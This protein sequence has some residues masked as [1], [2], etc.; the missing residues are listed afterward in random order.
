MV[1][2]VVEVC[3]CVC[4]CVLAETIMAGWTKV[5]GGAPRRQR[6]NISSNMV[7]KSRVE[8]GGLEQWT[9]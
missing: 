4:V 9:S 8:P 3:V 6:Y 1:V 5:W 2:V 7:E